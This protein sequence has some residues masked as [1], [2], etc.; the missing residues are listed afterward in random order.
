MY[1]IFGLFNRNYTQS[2]R[3]ITFTDFGGKKN[4]LFCFCV[5]LRC[6][7]GP[8]VWQHCVT[9]VA[10]AVALIGYKLVSLAPRGF[11]SRVPV[12]ANAQ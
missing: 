5:R 9:N 7:F 3:Y 12:F 6:V 11:H 8:T 1:F 2:T 4:I 10:H